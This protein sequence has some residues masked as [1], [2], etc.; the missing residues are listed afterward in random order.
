MNTTYKVIRTKDETYLEFLVVEGLDLMDQTRHESY[1]NPRQTRTA[2]DDETKVGRNE[3]DTDRQTDRQ[4]NKQTSKQTN[5]DMR[6]LIAKIERPN[7]WV[8][9]DDIS[10]ATHFT[11]IG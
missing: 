10:R 5:I 6:F 9:M 3:T 1:I 4:T 11:L 2:Y 7:R 8:G